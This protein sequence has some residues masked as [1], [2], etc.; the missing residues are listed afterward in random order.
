MERRYDLG[1]SPFHNAPPLSA[2][3]PLPSIKRSQKYITL[4][5][6][7]RYLTEKGDEISCKSLLGVLL[8]YRV[9]GARY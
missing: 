1:V 9:I 7:C 6:L 3:R 4:Y 2:H 5:I 8:H